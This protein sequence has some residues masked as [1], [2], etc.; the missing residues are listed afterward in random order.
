MTTTTTPAAAAGHGEPHRA[1]ISWQ[2]TSADFRYET[3]N[4]E[5]KW[6]FGGGITV[7]ASAAPAYRGQASHANPEEALVAAL[8]SCHMLTFL[9]IAARKGLVVD[10]YHD[11]AEGVLAKN[12]AG[13]LAVT[14]V[15]LRPAV[16]FAGPRPDAAALAELH[17]QAHLGCFIASSVK[18]EVVVEPVEGE[19]S[20]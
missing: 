12:D 7:D 15:T 14:R 5:H 6:T 19:P 18:T 13:R 9:A 11:A 16:R 3:Y 2:R 20:L 4:R 1:E 10:A 8:S 17:H